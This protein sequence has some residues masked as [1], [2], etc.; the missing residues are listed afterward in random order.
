MFRFSDYGIESDIVILAMIAVFTVLLILLIVAFVKIGKMKDIKK[1]T[2]LEQ[3]F[4]E[5][6]EK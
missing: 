5:L 4:L 6:G 3:V 2:S 1:D